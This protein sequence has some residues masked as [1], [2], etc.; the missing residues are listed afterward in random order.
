MA[1][2]DISF[3][4]ELSRIA[5]MAFNLHGLTDK[6]GFAAA[7][8]HSDPADP[9]A[10]RAFILG[11][12]V[13]AILDPILTLIAAIAAVVVWIVWRQKRRRRDTILDLAWQEVLADPHY[14]ERRSEEERRFFD[15][16]TP[17]RK[18]AR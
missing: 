17:R 3:L 11:P 1:L 2:H 14:H 5:N 15:D 6:S 12:P 16:D 13:N 18:P 7:L 4:A 10:G 9:A 8:L